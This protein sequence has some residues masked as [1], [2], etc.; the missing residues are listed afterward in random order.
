VALAR[1]DQKLYSTH[2]D[3]DDDAH[4]ARHAFSPYAS[5]PSTASYTHPPPRTTSA[6]PPAAH[7]RRGS[8]CALARPCK[9]AHRGHRRRS[10]RCGP[11][12]V[13]GSRWGVLLVQPVGPGCADLCRSLNKQHRAQQ[14]RDAAA[15]YLHPM[16]PIQPTHSHT[17][18]PP[19]QTKPPTPG[20]GPEVVLKSLFSD[21]SIT[22]LADITVFA[23]RELLARSHAELRQCLAAHDQP[24][25]RAADG[26]G[27]GAQCIR[28]ADWLPEL[29]AVPLHNVGLKAGVVPG[30][31][32]HLGTS[33]SG[34]A[35]FRFLEAAITETMAGE[36]GWL[37]GEG[38]KG[39]HKSHNS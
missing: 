32:P 11:P 20:I 34:E 5:P 8:R 25:R 17:P 26:G 36:A 19:L 33:A 35:S 29:D 37:G 3:D 4:T 18:P 24:P 10:G 38:P 6:P 15:T 27:A 1:R 22:Q 12:A 30:V 23:N 13:T 39:G 14:A 9:A 16:Q 2:V 21:P 31:V 7:R 28:S